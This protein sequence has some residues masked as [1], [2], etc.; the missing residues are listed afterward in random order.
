AISADVLT[1]A[2]PADFLPEPEAA[3]RRQWETELLQSG[4]S[5]SAEEQIGE[6][7]NARNWLTLHRPVHICEQTLLLSSSLD[8]TE[9][10]Q[11]ELKLARHAHYDELTG[12]PNRFLI[13]QQLE[14]RLQA[15]DP[16][17]FALAFIDIDN[18]KH[19]NDYYSHTI[20]DL[21]L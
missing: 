19:I 2:S 16:T 9:R 5:V 7:A 13:Q 10:K 11:F 15:N 12:L 4:R 17:P 14:Q 6:G 21:L 3:Q 8:I 20:G 18:F 1:G